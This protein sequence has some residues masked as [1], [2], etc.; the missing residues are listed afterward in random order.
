VLVDGAG[1]RGA[2][3]LHAQ[4]GEQAIRHRGLELLV[5]LRLAAL[6]VLRD[7]LSDGRSDLRDGREVSGL[8]DRADG[9]AEIADLAGGGAVRDR[10]EDVLALQLEEVTDLV[11]QVGDARV[12]FGCVLAWHAS[13]GS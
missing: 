12:L 11:E 3:A 8:V 1:G 7:G 6:Q 2:D 9:L 10:A 13:D 5:A 4:E